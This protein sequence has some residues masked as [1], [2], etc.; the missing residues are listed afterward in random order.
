MC[1]LHPHLEDLPK[2]IGKC[3]RARCPY[4]KVL[5]AANFINPTSHPRLMQAG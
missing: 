2:S 4:C 5:V 3:K 1:W